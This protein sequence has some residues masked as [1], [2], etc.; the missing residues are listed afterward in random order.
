MA[1]VYPSGGGHLL[2]VQDA[3]RKLLV[4][5]Y[6]DAYPKTVNTFVNETND[7]L[8]TYEHEFMEATAGGTIVALEREM[9]R[10]LLSRIVASRSDEKRQSPLVRARLKWLCCCD[11]EPKMVADLITRIIKNAH[12]IDKYVQEAAECGMGRRPSKQD[13]DP[14]TVPRGEQQ[15]KSAE[16]QAR[17]RAESVPEGGCTGCGMLKHGLKDCRLTQ[18][19]HFNKSSQP[20]AASSM[21]QRYAAQSKTQLKY[22]QDVKDNKIVMPGAAPKKSF[23]KGAKKQPWQGKRGSLRGTCD[24]T[25]TLTPPAYMQVNSLLD[26]GAVLGNYCSRAVGEWV[27]QHRPECW[28]T[29]EGVEEIALATEGASTTS[30]GSCFI[31]LILEDK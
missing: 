30:L 5:F 12:L 20:W 25:N 4:E 29:A 24:I 8:K 19:P 9:V 26:T 31:D 27:R 15:I 10:I 22:G 3:L 11:G 1:K 2:H 18:H 28:R 17:L 6:L 21:G 7:V 13:Q 14:E 23:D 16:A